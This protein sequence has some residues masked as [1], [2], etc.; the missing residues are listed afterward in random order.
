MMPSGSQESSQGAGDRAEPS[1]TSSKDTSSLG[2]SSDL[3]ANR[4]LT[5][6]LFNMVVCYKRMG[7]FLEPLTDAAEVLRYLLG[8]KM[9][10]CSLFCCIF[11]N[12]LFITLSEAAWFCLLL[13][14][15]SAP[16]ALGYVGERCQADSS[17]AAVQ[18]KKHHAVQ[19]RELN[20][21]R[22]SRQDA[23][24]EVKG[25]LKQLD[26]LLS[27]AC[28]YAE[29]VYKIL[30]WESHM[31]S[32]VFY[33]FLLAV[34]CL[35]YTVPVGWSL[36]AINSCVFIWNKDFCRVLLQ[37]KDRVHSC[38]V[39]PAEGEP[40]KC[41]SI[42]SNPPD[43]SPTPTS[44]EDLSP[45]S[46]EEAEEA[47]PDEDFKD[48]IEENQLALQES[49][50]VFVDDDE[51]AAA[52]AGGGDYD[53][54]SDNGL[55]SRNEPIR[56]RVSKLTERLRKR[57]PTNPT[58]NCSS[59]AAAFSV[60]KKRRFCTNCGVSYCSRCCSYKVFKSSMGATAPEAQRET[61]F[62]CAPCNAAL[63][64]KQDLHPVTPAS[65]HHN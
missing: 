33:G 47:E 43:R 41:D 59:C 9:P 63:S 36:S 3:S 14:A 49:Q 55:L 29:S 64:T 13:L 65:R 61:V 45:G 2:S 31:T 16:A 35:L 26:E 20:T 56:S 48:A 57:V 38:P 53:S 58:G 39:P 8:W 6:D 46:V 10:L 7:I 44:L 17:E 32:G 12:V 5:V 37:V 24:M 15:V 23:M 1:Q 21:V 40:E 19:R 52:A 60:L 25:L 18:K 54:A 34:V 42:S 11:L 62:V 28:V 51:A 50:L 22:M 30:Y 4:A 27:Q